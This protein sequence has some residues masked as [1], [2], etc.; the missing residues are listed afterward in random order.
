MDELFEKIAQADEYEVEE[1]LKAI[2]RRYAEV[3]PDWEVSMVSLHK[4]A[5]R[6]EQIDRIIKMLESMK[7]PVGLSVY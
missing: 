7:Q 3:F 1:L 5:D 2:L 4:G 6:K